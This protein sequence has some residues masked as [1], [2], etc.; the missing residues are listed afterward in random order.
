MNNNDGSIY[1]DPSES[2]SSRIADLLR[3]LT[4][5]EKIGQLLQTDARN[6]LEHNIMHRFAGSI[7]HASPEQLFQAADYVA[8]TCMRIPLLIGDDLIHGYSF[9]PGAT[10]YPTQL[11]MAATWSPQLLERM[12]RATA[13]EAT[14][15]GI[16]WTF[17]PVLCI[18][19]DLRW[20]RVDESFGE[21]PF[22]I[23]E[24][25]SA[26]VR[27]YQGA[28]LTDPTSL[29]ATAKH[30]A[31]YSQTQGGRDASEADLTRRNLQSWFL[32]PFE[33]VARQGCATFM[34]G[35][36]SID[37]TP[38]TVNRWILNDVLR[39]AWGYSGMLVTDWDNVG[40][41]VWEQRLQ[42]DIAHAAAA[43]IK[44][45]NDMIMTTPHFFEGA[46]QAVQDTLLSVEEIDAAVSR[47]LALKFRL[48]LFENPRLPRLDAIKTSMNTV[49]HQKLN[50]EI[51][52]RSVVVL[53]N[54]GTL[55]LM[56][57]D[58]EHA[59]K[60]SSEH[61]MS[62]IAVVGP[63]ADDAQ[64]QLGDWAG[65]SGQVPWLSGQPRD[66]ITTILDGMHQ[67]TPQDTAIVYAKGAEILTTA[68]DPDGD[69]LPDGQPAPAIAIPASVNPEM[70]DE[71]VEAF[72]HAD[73]AI[74]VVGDRIE[75]VGEGRS[76][77]T[78]R[79]F[80]A[81]N[82]LIDAIAAESERSAKPFVI[83]MLASKPLILPPSAQ[84]ASGVLWVGNPGMK[85]G[86][87]IAEVILGMVEPCG[88]LPISFAKDAGQLPIFYN[89]VRGQHGTRY[90]DLDQQPEY[91]FGEGLSYT[92]IAY[93]DAAI[94]QEQRVVSTTDTLN[95][96]VTVANTGNR[97][98]LETVQLYIRDCVTS[99]TWADKELKA[100]KQVALGAGESQRVELSI[101]VSDCSIVNAAEER[102]VEPGD[103]EA[104][105]GHSS[106][107]KDLLAVEFTVR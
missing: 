54:D 96:A 91:A 79:L 82:A 9:W 24:L 31:G 12:A 51:A 42:P 64:T 69:V 84:G 41:L 53:K 32:P 62:S 46:L 17:S 13:E 35:Y 14:P 74:L 39:G 65:G 27:G 81:Q 75:L 11:A 95:V 101:P 49:Q 104:L 15:T 26:M 76:T 99:A 21:D 93:S 4:L 98:C 60:A 58:C 78:L 85:G 2:I 73:V 105:V 34:L 33:R 68:P 70:I 47:V 22:L 44:A 57:N 87:A 23:G 100:F 97:P 36:E 50:L 94:S 19:R 7:L 43:A 1:R 106:K 83:V 16:H 66:M 103:F 86:Q 67:C 18:A 28:G 52:R 5:E 55:P 3:R 30:F 38:I 20:G 6:E 72:A 90:A 37:G 63:L 77:A 25:G 92:T 89:Q 48:G 71:A 56:C 59:D 102:V 107:D 10:I 8:Q 61:R 29:L 88:R 45:G 40:R 80:G